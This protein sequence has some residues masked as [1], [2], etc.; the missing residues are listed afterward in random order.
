[1]SYVFAFLDSDEWELTVSKNRNYFWEKKEIEKYL[2][3]PLHLPLKRLI[4]A[5]IVDK[6]E[7]KDDLLDEY[8]IIN[9]ENKEW[10]LFH[11]GRDFWPKWRKDDAHEKI[12][13]LKKE[14]QNFSFAKICSF[15]TKITLRD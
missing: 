15:D 6:I 14:N 1:M 7:E 11:W 10:K 13:E 2:A 8:L 12:E 3:N 4:A 9:T 5:K